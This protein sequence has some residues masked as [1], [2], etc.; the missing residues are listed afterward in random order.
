[1][2]AL[3]RNQSYLYDFPITPDGIRAAAKGG[4]AAQGF[5][6]RTVGDLP[7][8][9]DRMLDAMNRS[10]YADHPVILLGAP[11]QVADICRRLEERGDRVELPERSML[12]VSGGWKS[13]EGEKISRESLITVV[14]ERLGIQPGR[15]HESYG[16]TECSTV[17]P[18]CASERF[19][20]PP[21][22]WPMVVD[23]A[24]VPMS[25][26]G[27]GRYGFSDPDATSFPGLFITGDEAEL[28]LDP[29]ACGRPGFSL[30][31]EIR[32]APGREVKG[33][34]GVMAAVRG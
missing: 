28:T 34:G 4:P 7:A 23:D 25:G 9:Y 15:Y 27:R 19:H 14:G 30:V 32:R 24:L 11:F 8:R 6:D 18:I 2:S 31:G 20:I 33:C 17:S 26:P 22:I 3:T 12:F 10:A 1:M 21:A 16:M 13:F 29:C 5:L